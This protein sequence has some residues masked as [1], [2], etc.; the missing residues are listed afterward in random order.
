MP[1]PLPKI[2]LSNKLYTT[3]L[4]YWT[5]YFLET[6]VN[7][8]AEEFV[9]PVDNVT[10]Y[11]CPK[12][13]KYLSGTSSGPTICIILCVLIVIVGILGLISNIFNIIV[14]RNSMKESF[15]R[16]SLI[17]LAVFDIIVSIF[18]SLTVIFLQI[19]LDN[20]NRGKVI[21][22]LLQ[23]VGL[24]HSL[25]RTGS[26]FI[27]ILVS[28]ERYL[29]VAY[30]FQAKIWLAGRRSRGI[31]FVWLFGIIL[32][33]IP[34]WLNAVIVNTNLKKFPKGQLSKYPY[35]FVATNFAT[36]VYT[37]LRPFHNFVDFVLPLPL[38]LV[39]NGLLFRSI[40]KWNKRREVL[41]GKHTREINAAKMFAVIVVALFSCHT[42]GVINFIIGQSTGTMYRELIL[43]IIFAVALNATVNFFVYYYFGQS[44]RDHFWYFF[45]NKILGHKDYT[46]P[47]LEVGRTP[48]TSDILQENVHFQRKNGRNE[49]CRLLGGKIEYELRDV[50]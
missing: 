8:S 35:I 39:F 18:A 28:I 32:I 38:L 37:W 1:T 33:N 5:C 20:V 34:W 23:F 26:V 10:V 6:P 42:F 24:L 17:I 21:L 15:L 4:G 9:S 31:I 43:S 36:G 3:N 13:S 40:Y 49:Q 45:G 16:H 27:T 30:P 46:L 14:L 47:L 19:I 44:F 50:E 48:D 7:S 41:T 22:Y 25:G 11:R 12:Y 29:V 2:L